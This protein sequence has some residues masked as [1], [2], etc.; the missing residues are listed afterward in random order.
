MNKRIPDRQRPRRRPHGTAAGSRTTLPNRPL[1]VGILPNL[2]GYNVRRAHM[3]LWRDFN[4][5]VGTGVVRPGL[6]SMMVLVDENPGIAQIELATQLDIDKATIVGLIRQLQRQGW[7]DRRQ[8]TTDRRRQD[9][10]LTTPG[11][12]QLAILRRE[13]LEHEQRFLNLFS[14]EELTDFFNFLRRIQI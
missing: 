4:R 2:L 13:M 14:R 3:A 5:T 6:F 11:R 1:N 8:S 12:Q 10:Y 7:L 9:L